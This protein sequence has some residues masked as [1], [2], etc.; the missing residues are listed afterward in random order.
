MSSE[1]ERQ[2]LPFEPKSGRKKSEKKPPQQAQA[3]ES[4]SAQAEPAKPSKRAKAQ[5][6]ASQEKMQIP[7]VVSQR[8]MRRMAAF[9]GIPTALG[10]VSFFV[11]YFV[12]VN[13]WF[14]LPNVAVLLVSMGFF[15]LGVLG[16]S[17]GVLSA[18]WDEEIAGSS[19]GWAEFQ[20]NIGRM[21]QAW[22]SARKG[23]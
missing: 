2:S 17:Y 9:S 15:G 7:E 16:L 20:T 12:T 6:A 22:R 19:L 11:S 13:G 1:P 3:A 8:M 4:A 23:S 21:T 5:S 14:P 18:S 10:V